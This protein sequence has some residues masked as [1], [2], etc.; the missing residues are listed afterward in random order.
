MFSKPTSLSN[1]FVLEKELISK[2]H[3]SPYFFKSI[4][5]MSSAVWDR[6]FWVTNPQKVNTYLQFPLSS[7]ELLFLA[8][9]SSLFWFSS[10]QSSQS[11]QLCFQ[12]AAVFSNNKKAPTVH[13]LP[14]QTGGQLAKK[15]WSLYQPIIFFSGAGD[16]NSTKRRVKIGLD[17]HQVAKTLTQSEC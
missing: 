8:S 13:N 4:D 17:L 15:K 16:Q 2:L 9:F 6:L 10:S 5:Q 3:W 12:H 11:Y 7:K 14:R 1:C